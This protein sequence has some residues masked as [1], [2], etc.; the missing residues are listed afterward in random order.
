M[1]KIEI[2]GFRSMIRS[3]RDITKRFRAN[4]DNNYGEKFEY[5]NW[6][7]TDFDDFLSG[8]PLTPEDK[9]LKDFRKSLDEI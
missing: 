4:I 9:N 5:T 6:T 7:I 3:F 2:G 8:N 1:Y